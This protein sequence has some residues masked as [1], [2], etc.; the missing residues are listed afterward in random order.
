MQVDRELT[1]RLMR[2]FA[3]PVAL[4]EQLRNDL[5][6][7]YSA[8]L[9][10]APGRVSLDTL[11]II[12]PALLGSAARSALHGAVLCSIPVHS[13]LRNE[14]NLLARTQRRFAQHTYPFLPMR[15]FFINSNAILVH[16]PARPEHQPYN[17]ARAHDTALSILSQ[18]DYPSFGFEFA[19]T[20]EKTTTNLWELPDAVAEG[21]GM[22]SRNHHMYS[23]FSAYLVQSVAGMSQAKGSAGYAELDLRPSR[24]YALRGASTTLEL[25]HGDVHFSW[26]RSGGTQRDKVAEGD[27]A[28]L[29]CGPHGGRIV[30]VDFASF[31]TPTAHGV[32]GFGMMQHATCHASRSKAVVAALCVGRTSCT[33]PA[34]KS[35]FE[36]SD[37]EIAQCRAAAAADV[38][39]PHADPLR[40]WIDVQC[41]KPDTIDA[42]ATV[43]IG[44][45]ATMRLPLRGM[46]QPTLHD[47][48][49]T[50]YYYGD[51]RVVAPSQAS[52]DV[53]RELDEEMGE[54][55][56]VRF[57]AGEYNFVLTDAG[58]TS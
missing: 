8:R 51:G 41:E 50:Y 5:V 28:E 21:T 46:A 14:S 35:T 48:A 17:A 38:R 49:G 30:G 52:V 33:V 11:R 45:R 24:A 44:S 20:L 58:A 16:Q 13:L 53:S 55:I 26:E 9:Y 39:G 47:M 1:K 4:P 57:A 6:S 15:N 25:P 2:S 37:N 40:L 34:S 22:N 3:P 43:P 19:N 7:A 56:R 54:V 18:T 10:G 32:A 42:R 29:S 36:T 12:W 31:G 27:V 23:S